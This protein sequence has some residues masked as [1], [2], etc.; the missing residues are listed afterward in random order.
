MPDS[1]KKLFTDWT[2]C[3]R[4][5]LSSAT[6]SVEFTRCQGVNYHYWLR[7]T[8]TGDW[9]CWSRGF[10]FSNALVI[11]HTFIR[12]S[13]QRS[14]QPRLHPKP[15]CRFSVAVTCSGWSLCWGSKQAYLIIHQLVSM[16]SQ[17]S[18][19]AWLSVWL[20]EISADF[21]EVVVHWRHLAPMRYINPCTVLYFLLFYPNLPRVM[22][23]IPMV[24]PEG[25]GFQPF[26]PCSLGRSDPYT[27]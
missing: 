6:V 17:C 5:L 25:P 21:R 18:L 27:A 2:T 7:M 4:L 9:K 3:S 12:V 13:Q 22:P 1:P 14:G 16:V 11:Y 23:P 19:N 10:G 20:A 15:H 26:T 24:G 8:L